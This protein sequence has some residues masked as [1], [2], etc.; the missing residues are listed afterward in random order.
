LGDR[1]DPVARVRRSRRQSRGRLV[2]RAL[3]AAAAGLCALALAPAGALGAETVISFDEAGLASGTAL[4]GKTI[5]GVT[6]G[7]S[8][9]GPFFYG[10]T[11]RKTQEASEAHSPP[12]VLEVSKECGGF[13]HT[14]IWGRFAAP[15]SHVALFI[16]N[17]KPN[18]LTTATRPVTLQGFDLSGNEIAS[19]TVVP[20]KG[21]G[22]T[23]ELSINDTSERISFF[24]LV[25]VSPAECPV[26][27]DDL[28]FNAFAAEVPPE[29]G[30]SAQ[31]IGTT[32][33]AGSS[34]NVTLQLHRTATSTGPVSLGVSGLPSGVGASISPNPTNGS[35]LSTMTLT[36]IAGAQA[37][38]AVNVP[39]TVTAT[40]SPTAGSATHTTTFPLSVSGNFD[41]RAQG[42]EV[43]QG[44]QREGMLAP[45]GGESG[46]SYHGVN[47]VQ[48]KKTAV[49]FYADAHGAPSAG[50]PGVYAELVG[51]S[52]G[53]PLPG[54][55]LYPDY[56]PVSLPDTGEADPAPV[57]QGERTSDANAFTFTL[58]PS[59]TAGTSPIK[60]VATIFGPPP[61]FGPALLE[62]TAPSCLAN[63]SFAEENVTFNH[64]GNAELT[65]IDLA[66]N[67][68][69][70]AG[71]N[72][73]FAKSKLVTP[74]G[75]LGSNPY[76]PNNGFDV[77]PYQGS[78]DISD[79]INNNEKGFDKRAA[80]KSRVEQWRSDNGN[81][82]FATYGVAKT[83]FGGVTSGGSSVAVFQ[84]TPVP[85]SSDD[86]PLTAIAHELFHLFGLQH[87]SNECGGGNQDGDSDDH[88]Q[89]GVPWPLKPG[90]N[91]DT[92]E[93]NNG[94]SQGANEADNDPPNEGFGQLLGVGLDMTSEPYRILADGDNGIA[95]YYD[96]MSYCAIFRGG[97]DP[98]EWVSPTN[99]EAVFRRFPGGFGASAGEAG[100]PSSV[101]AAAERR[102][103]GPLASVAALHSGRLRVIAYAGSDVSPTGFEITSVGPAVGP[104]LAAGSSTYVLMARGSHGQL[105][106]TVPM[107]ASVGHEDDAASLDELTAE[108]PSKGAQSIEI[109]SGGKVLASRAR[110]PHPP[111]L[112]IVA[113]RKAS[114]VGGRRSVLVR[115]H[116]SDRDHLP[117]T[118]SV[119]YSRDD[120]RSW[121]TLF[122]GDNHGALSL[123]GF[124]FVGSRAARVRVRV[125]DGFN[126]TAAVSKRFSAL[127]APPAVSIANTPT[128]IAGDAR[129]QLTGEAFDQRMRLLSGRSVR[130]FDGPFALGSGTT[131]S[132]GPLPPG[133]NHIRLV[134]RD[135]TG[136]SAAASVT[137][138]VRPANL[139]FLKLALP[140]RVSRR[141][142]KLVF[143]ASSAVAATLT[144]GKRSF[145]V[146]TK[147]AK[148]SLPI[149]R[150]APLLLHLSVREGSVT[151]PFAAAVPRR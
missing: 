125:N 13:P 9:L 91:E 29:I 81:P 15:R 72:V 33:A 120:G 38:P 140:T 80:A 52:H 130:W 117:L 18:P 102:R 39:V 93:Q 68:T 131:L 121:R 63:N 137:V 74:L 3:Q 16:G 7:E 126:E 119:D 28:S 60:L 54:S 12:N 71:P 115:W 70:P 109:A 85:I 67:G 133:A 4:M 61:S 143:S 78:V 57:G 92:V 21:Y 17:I 65:T 112:A 113:P 97:G 46:G 20:P 75:D 34:V 77:T 55:P 49:R 148:L 107:A 51:Y 36:L 30:I 151:I 118:V 50:I 48:Y 128:A 1:P 59:W 123:P 43:T 145:E 66:A 127:G 132:A 73:V 64:T 32:V 41:L 136:H 84:P 11:V 111:R 79:I 44:I 122:V 35:D 89:A 139:P 2:R 135:A 19:N 25:S 90:A 42:I 58:P 138:N 114:Q 47:L 124:Y 101:A 37:P 146:T 129:V 98:G 103:S 40:P 141:A 99:W 149:S 100:G 134:A 106:R 82:G 94:S 147:T 150:R 88:D 86:R 14:E 62:C 10:G 23:A 8:P 87:A 69:G 45:S 53:T 76:Q 144:I 116:A 142:T 110:D 83:G 96:F 6:F 95:E 105:L 104:A 24:K 108:V 26:A 56:G 31:T 5:K 27:I 22:V